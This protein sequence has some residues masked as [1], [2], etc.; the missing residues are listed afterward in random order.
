M[1]KFYLFSFLIIGI[2][3]LIGLRID[4]MDIDAAQ[5]ASI[6]REMLSTG[7]FLQVY[8][9]G[10]DYLDKP[11]FLFWVSA[12]SMKI[13][14][15]SNFSYKLPSFL[16]AIIAVFSTYKLSKLFYDNKTAILSALILASSQG[17]FLMTHDV[18]TD[19]ILMAWVIFSVW[20]L[21]SWIQHK[22]LYHFFLGVLA[23][24]FGM[25]TKGPIALL[26]PCFAI[27]SHLIAQK[28]FSYLFKWEYVLGVFIISFLLLPMSW[29]LFKQFDLHPE[30][31]VNGEHHVSGLRFFY[32]TQS[33]GRIT[34]ESSWN[35]N[36]NIFFLLQNMLWSFLPWIIIFL[37]ALI[38]QIKILVSNKLRVGSKQEFITLGGFILTYLSLG[39]SKYQLP[40]YIFVGFPFAA[41]ITAEFLNNLISDNKYPKFFKQILYG[42][43]VI[44][45]LLWIILVL[46]LAISFNTIHW[47]VSALAFIVLVGL[48]VFFLKNKGERKILIFILIY[49]SLGLNLFLNTWLYPSL[50]NYQAGS[51]VGKWISANN[52]PT[53][54]TYTYKFTIWRSLNFYSKA[55]IGNKENVNTIGI[56]DYIITTENK[57]SELKN[58][59]KNF[60]ILYQGSDFP[61]T[62]LNLKFL[63]PKN[64]DGEL[65]TFVLILIK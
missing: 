13:F 38:F 41:I 55:I 27:G 16:F 47:Y 40:H 43:L 56:G 9:L 4:I 7:H 33:F 63:N 34:G 25:M 62:R 49:T 23:I 52:I 48:I 46:I 39:L 54:K 36:S 18:R 60:K 59:G 11:P 58:Q 2:I 45:I 37:C 17:F 10:K 31:L 50:L 24:A 32:W 15:I 21:A 65:E 12:I 57:L 26:V 1:N 29:G 64:R 51:S 28:K 30:K 6:S 22:K 61:V 14:G 20:Q 3:C 42:H 53:N 44:F 35:N 8:D 19:T 5:Y